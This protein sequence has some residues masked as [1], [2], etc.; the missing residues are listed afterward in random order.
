[1]VFPEGPPSPEPTRAE[2]SKAPEAPEARVTE[3][4]CK[5]LRLRE[6]YRV[7]CSEMELVSGNREGVSFDCQMEHKDQVSCSVAAV[8]FPARR[9]DRRAF[10]SMAWTKWGM[11]PNAVVTE[12]FLEGDPYPL[13]TMHG[14]HWGF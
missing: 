12:Q 1:V 2:W 4:G 14:L 13:I 5:V 9:G 11:E 7:E 6:W 8:V 10:D 3:P